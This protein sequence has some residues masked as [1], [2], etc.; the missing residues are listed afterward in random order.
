MFEF[1]SF[2]HDFSSPSGLSRFLGSLPSYFIIILDLLWFPKFSVRRRL[3]LVRQK[4]GSNVCWQLVPQPD[5][6]GEEAVCMA[7]DV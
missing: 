5:G 2:F 4:W 6:S 3:A 1:L 7:E